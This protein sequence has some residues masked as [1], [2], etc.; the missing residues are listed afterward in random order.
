MAEQHFA[1]GDGILLRRM[2]EFINEAFDDEDIVGR[3]H[4]PP[5]SGRNSRRLDP[6][7]IDM[8]SDAF[9][10]CSTSFL[11]SIEALGELET[12]PLD[13]ITWKYLFDRCGTK[14]AIRQITQKL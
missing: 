4:P 2:G 8:K 7:V 13:A 9:L 3:A 12:I 11:L 10:S 14:A 1:I 6:D 5:K